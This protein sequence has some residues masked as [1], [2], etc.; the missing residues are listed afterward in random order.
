M[1]ATGDEVDDYC[2]GT[3]LSSPSMRRR[4]CHRRDGGVDLVVMASLPSPMRRH[5]SVVDYD[6]NGLMGNTVNDD[7]DDAT[8]FAVIAMALL[9]SSR[10]RRCH[11]RSAQASCRC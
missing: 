6:G 7:G 1:M 4:L 8:D 5:L 2:D 9:P 10:W 3:K 11:C